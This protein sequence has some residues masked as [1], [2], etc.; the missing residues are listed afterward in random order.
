MLPTINDHSVLRQLSLVEANNSIAYARASRSRI[1]RTYD[2]ASKDEAAVIND[3]AHSGELA[4]ML[5]AERLLQTYDRDIYAK[6]EREKSNVEAGLQEFERVLGNYEE[7]IQRPGDY[8]RQAK[9]YSSRD[10]DK[11][12]GVP[13]DG[14]RRVLHSQ[15][16][17]LKNRMSLTLSE[18]EKILLTARLN[19]LNALRNAYAFLQKKV[20]QLEDLPLE[21]EV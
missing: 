1:Q 19:L 3:I 2:Q 14:M 8:R 10:V 18:E 4:L 17:R 12:L 5:A 15:S 16:T 11:A 7:L 20:V 21:T 13:M 6:T 9:H